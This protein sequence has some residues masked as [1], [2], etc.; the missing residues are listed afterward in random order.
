M[1][2]ASDA[3][4]VA[5]SADTRRTVVKVETDITDPDLKYN[6]FSGVDESVISVHEQTLKNSHEI[7]RYVTLERNY[8]ILDGGYDIFDDNYQQ[9]SQ[10]DKIGFV[11]DGIC[12]DN[13]S[14]PSAQIITIGMTYSGIL[15]AAEIMFSEDSNDGVP[16]D[17]TVDIWAGSVKVY[18][19]SETNNKA[20]TTQREGFEA[21]NPDKIVITIRKWSVPARRTRLRYVIPGLHLVWSGD[22][23]A[24][25]SVQQNTDPSCATLPYGTAKLSIDNSGKVFEPRNKKGY[26]RS[27][28]ERQR[29]EISIGLYVDG[30]IEY[31]SV[32]TFY[33]KAGGWSSSDNGLSIEWELVDIIGAL[34]DRKFVLPEETPKTLDGWAKALVSH[35]GENFADRY[36]VDDN[37]KN[38]PVIISKRQALN[39]TSVA[40]MIRFL[41]LATG[42]WPRA[43]AETGNLTFEP[44]WD[45][46]VRMSLHN[47]AEYPTMYEN[48]D[49]SQVTVTKPE[50]IDKYT[51]EVS[52]A[53]EN[54][55]GGTNLASSKS[56][57]IES[58]FV[59]DE[60]DASRI[61]TWVIS[62]F[63][64]NAF[65]VT[66][67]GDPTAE[68]GDVV[69]LE[70]DESS[71]ITARIIEQSFEY[72]TGVLA[73]C[74]AKLIQPQGYWTYANGEKYTANGTFV[75]P[76]GVN[77]IKVIVVGGGTGGSPGSSG[78]FDEDGEDGIDGPGGKVYATEMN[79][80]PGT[81]Y[82]IRI[83]AG[84]E[85]FREKPGASYFGNISSEDGKN[86]IPSYTDILSGSA[87]GRTGVKNPLPN[88]GDGGKCGKGGK[89]GESHTGKK[90]DDYGFVTEI[91]IVDRE[92][93][94]G[95][96]GS[97][98]AS[99]CVAV[100]WN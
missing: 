90:K 75:V 28:Q 36:K 73:N 26:F 78:D 40:D 14:L 61:F 11:S 100:Y 41:S 25:L 15:Q 47:M 97:P 13:G 67:R 2:S 63:G 9:R 37:Y 51:K 1:I 12:R 46:G 35:L 87:Y 68:T 62:Q 81:S 8:W 74:K 44:L 45:Q 4:R 19:W 43:D 99:G 65:D 33:Q 70:L 69:T 30:N 98:G 54:V 76:D 59:T 7:S 72:G 82:V 34:G 27:I 94:A 42:T 55:F 16:S 57:N 85:T 38:I 53:E 32:G 64:G 5:V 60:I 18:S 22:D 50:L 89:K 39:D 93:T 92:P 48:E 21:Y 10:K 20:T 49:V 83:G 96:A 66:W 52:F 79:V 17:F 6:S 86:Y 80:L 31:K 56:I 91:T 23:I 77:V 29:V 71:A 95:T 24:S 88:T 3:Y 58:P 84:S